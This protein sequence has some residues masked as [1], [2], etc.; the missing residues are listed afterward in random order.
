[1]FYMQ[2]YT[3]F[4]LVFTLIFKK[5]FSEIQ[6][7]HA[8][9]ML[10]YGSIRTFQR[11]LLYAVKNWTWNGFCMN[12]QIRVDM[13]YIYTM[14]SNSSQKETLESKVLSKAI[15][16][17]NSESSQ[18][19]I[20]SNWFSAGNSIQILTEIRILIVSVWN[21]RDKHQSYLFTRFC[22]NSSKSHL[23]KGGVAGYNL[24]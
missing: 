7:T 19:P 17:M 20:E 18:K 13:I 1:M 4:E 10:L 23:M 15:S 21:S 3:K 12:L 14:N 16:T 5:Y 9:S 24:E 11:C 6:K 22:L 2:L 8:K